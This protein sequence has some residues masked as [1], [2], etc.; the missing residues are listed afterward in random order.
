MTQNQNTTSRT[1][2]QLQPCERGEIMALHNENWPASQIAKKL[3]RD[4]STITRELKRGATRQIGANHKPTTLTTPRQPKYF[5]STAVPLVMRLAGQIRLP[6]CS[7]TWLASSIKSLGHRASTPAF[8]RTKWL[9][10][11]VL[12]RQRR[13]SI[14][15]SMLDC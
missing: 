12:A 9:G 6:S 15:T 7:I 2:Q 10:L 14:A 4:R 11:I 3:H 8:T 1:Y 5:T 13:P